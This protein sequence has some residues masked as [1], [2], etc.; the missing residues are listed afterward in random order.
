MK[1][2]KIDERYI[3]ALYVLAMAG[4][5]LWYAYFKGWIF[6][7]FQ[8]VDARKAKYLIE[9]ETNLTIIDVRTPKEYKTGHV[10][11]AELFPL[12]TIENDLERLEP[13]K[14]TKL[15][16]YCRSGSRSV[17]ASRTLRSHGFVP[18]NVEGGIVA[19]QAVGVPI[20]K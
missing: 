17:S 15:L 13:F 12:Q 4:L 14:H 2:K 18:I 10:R 16:V 20:V 6:A 5:A 7:D 9:N 1:R 3:D 11:G 19:L 8:S